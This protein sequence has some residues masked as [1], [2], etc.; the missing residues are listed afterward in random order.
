MIKIACTVVGVLKAASKNNAYKLAAMKKSAIVSVHIKVKALPS[1]LNKNTLYRLR[2]GELNEKSINAAD[3]PNA[4]A[5]KKGE[6]GRPGSI[7]KEKRSTIKV[8]ESPTN[9]FLLKRQL[10]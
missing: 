7:K 2:L 8:A 10:S 6:D 1:S 5:N 3:T 9:K 4:T